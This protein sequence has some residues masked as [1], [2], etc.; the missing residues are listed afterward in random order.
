MILL[1]R[2]NEKVIFAHGFSKNE[3]SNITKTQ[4]DGFKIM[5]EP[6]LNL[7]SEQL[8][9]LIANQNLIEIEK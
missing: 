7:S 4:L 5:A 1:M 2:L 8:D 9:A 6:F 3:K